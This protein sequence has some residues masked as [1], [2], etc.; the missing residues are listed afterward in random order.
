MYLT[1]SCSEL[2]FSTS[3]IFLS[4]SYFSSVPRISIFS[5]YIC[6]QNH[7][8]FL[9]VITV[10][11]MTIMHWAFRRQFRYTVPIVTPRLSDGY[12]TQPDSKI[13]NKQKQSSTGRPWTESLRFTLRPIG[14]ILRTDAIAI[15]ALLVKFPWLLFDESPPPGPDSSFIEYEVQSASALMWLQ[16]ISSNAAYA[17]TCWSHIC[18]TWCM[19]HIP[20]SKCQCSGCCRAAGK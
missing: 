12:E 20:S 9:P 2:R 17:K 11:N 7:V 13:L 6:S 4:T 18:C 10:I 1:L 19:A 8:R 15:D 14:E 5:C 3:A 16:F